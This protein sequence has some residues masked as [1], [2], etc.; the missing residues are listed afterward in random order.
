MEKLTQIYE[1]LQDLG[2]VLFSRALPFCNSACKCA[3]IEYDGRY[4][5]FMD[6][7]R[8]DTRAEETVLAAHECGHIA[9]GTT[10]RVVSPI[11]LIGRH[12]YRANK[13]AILKLLPRDELSDAIAQGDR[14]P[15]ELAERLSLPES[16]IR[17]ALAFYRD[18]EEA[19]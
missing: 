7:D 2:A 18:Q 13:W 14:E 12:E 19:V 9:T 5:V 6:T 4:G 1:E 10:H 11:D 15:W 17:E 16:F 8:I 3:T